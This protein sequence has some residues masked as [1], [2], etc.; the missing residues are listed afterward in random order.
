MARILAR[1]SHVIKI[2]FSKKSF[3]K[4]IHPNHGSIMMQ[5]CGNRK[6]K[7]LLGLG[8][9]EVPESKREWI[10]SEVIGVKISFKIQ[11]C[12]QGCKNFEWQNIPQSPVTEAFFAWVPVQNRYRSEDASFRKNMQKRVTFAVRGGLRRENFPKVTVVTP[13]KKHQMLSENWVICQHWHRLFIQYVWASVCCSSKWRR[14][15][16][17]DSCSTN[18]SMLA[19]HREL[20]TKML[21]FHLSRIWAISWTQFRPG[22]DVLCRLFLMQK[23]MAGKAHG[24][25]MV[26]PWFLTEQN[27]GE[28]GW[29]IIPWESLV[30]CTQAHFWSIRGTCSSHAKPENPLVDLPFIPMKMAMNWSIWVAQSS[31]T[32]QMVR[33]QLPW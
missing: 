29:K 25:T 10:K 31:N 30:P 20:F 1:A 13:T 32:P 27:H 24:R 33:S 21:V 8:I 2:M 28:N 9:H 18:R 17:H 11:M 7:N 26:K 6:K 16:H 14:N 5:I 3:A 23:Q 12:W 15:P 4:T 22:E 19:E